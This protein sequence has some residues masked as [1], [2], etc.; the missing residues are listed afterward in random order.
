L[1]FLD[2]ETGILKTVLSPWQG[3]VYSFSPD[4]SLIAIDKQ[5]EI[6]L[7]S[8][9]GKELRTIFTYTDIPTEG[10]NYFYYYPQIVWK[11]GW[12]SLL[13]VIPPSNLFTDP[14]MST[15]VWRVPLDG[16]G[17]RKMFE[18]QTDIPA[19]QSR[20]LLDPTGRR[21][22]FQVTQNT[23]D[24]KSTAVRV[25]NLD[26]SGGKIYGNGKIRFFS[27]SPNGDYFIYSQ[28]H[29]PLGTGDLHVKRLLNRLQS[30]S[31]E[32]PII[33]ELTVADAQRSLT[34]LE[35]IGATK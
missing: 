6:C 12:R 25:E 26:G 20:P 1:H 30:H 8:P 33:F 32:G 19:Y 2:L 23:F 7:I 5:G 3:G 34:Y 16:S 15:V 11:M 14:P 4:G 28:D 31:Y 22:A 35:E 17:E 18:F 29:Q 24:P 21:I 10:H 13:V 9:D 27:W